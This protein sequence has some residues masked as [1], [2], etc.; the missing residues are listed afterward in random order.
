MNKNEFKKHIQKTLSELKLY[1]ELHAGIEL[2]NDFEFEWQ[3]ANKLKAVGKENVTELI[4][5]K[6]Y[7]NESKIYPC[8][9]LIVENITDDNR[10]FI[11]GRIAGFEPRAFG[12]GWS[13]RPGPFIYG[14]SSKILTGKVNCDSREFKDILFEKGLLHYKTE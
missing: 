3:F 13:N 5:E 14:V 4:A 2:P 7:L 11:S 8:V 1:A 10:I 9:D 6:V 12:R